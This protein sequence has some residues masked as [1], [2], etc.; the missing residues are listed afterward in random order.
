[1]NT[2]QGLVNTNNQYPFAVYE[3]GI[4]IA[5]IDHQ[6]NYNVLE[7]NKQKV[8]IMIKSGFAFVSVASLN[9]NFQLNV[10]K[11]QN[12]NFPNNGQQG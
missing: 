12:F 6:G 9:G 5:Y 1:M 8:A 11:Y 7:P 2:S 4:L 3:N 10:G